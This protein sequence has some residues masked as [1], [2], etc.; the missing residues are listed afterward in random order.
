M[1]YLG[2]GISIKLFRLGICLVFFG[3]L[4]FGNEGVEGESR[5]LIRS[6]WVIIGWDRYLEEIE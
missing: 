4:E 5:V 6:K 1:F 3:F 2:G